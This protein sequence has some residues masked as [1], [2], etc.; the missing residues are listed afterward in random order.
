MYERLT[1]K[2][3]IGAPFLENGINQ[4]KVS[5]NFPELMNRK[6]WTPKFVFEWHLK[7][8][9]YLYD[10][11]CGREQTSVAAIPLLDLLPYSYL[12]LL[13]KKEFW[14]T[15]PI[16]SI[17]L[18]SS[19]NYSTSYNVMQLYSMNLKISR[20]DFIYK[21]TQLEKWVWRI[22]VT[23]P[24][25]QKFTLNS[26]L[27]RLDPLAATIRSNTR[28]FRATPCFDSPRVHCLAY[29]FAGKI[30]I[31]VNWTSFDLTVYM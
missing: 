9:T 12:A 31:V 3:Y 4:M 29:S 22:K 28:S 24:S 8:H 7:L 26:G 27:P 25:G 18:H 14:N 13:L 21:W 6:R 2:E 17:F 15:N 23:F 5:E 10:V 16:T 30:E 1:G 19:T 11:Q 20:M